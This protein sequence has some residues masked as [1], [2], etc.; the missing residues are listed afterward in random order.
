MP[1]ENPSRT[2]RVVVCSSGGGGNLQAVLEGSLAGDYSV[3]RVITDRACGAEK[4]ARRF[5]LDPIRVSSKQVAEF[6]ENLMSE[7]PSDTDLVVLAGFMPIFK[8]EILSL[9]SGRIINTHPSLLPKFGGYGMYGVRVHEA[10]LESGERETGC[11]VH[12]VTENIDEGPILGQSRLA[13]DPAES[14]W[15]LGA[16]VFALEGPLLVEV[17]TCFAQGGNR[18]R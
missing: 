9:F 4:V 17:V 13:V 11:T 8:G 16:R 12:I 10:V 14:A 1:T 15:D 2:F 3:T 18:G 7:I 6:A 5:G